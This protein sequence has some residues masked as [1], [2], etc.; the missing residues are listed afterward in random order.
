MVPHGPCYL[1]PQTGSHE[2]VSFIFILVF[3]FFFVLIEETLR[4]GWNGK[5]RGLS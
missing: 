1:G 3:F 4:E 2:L 5:A